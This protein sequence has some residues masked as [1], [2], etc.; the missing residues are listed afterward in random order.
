MNKQRAWKL[1]ALCLAV[2]SLTAFLLW[3]NWW[4]ISFRGTAVVGQTKS[5]LIDRHGPPEY[6]SR[7]TP[8]RRYRPRDTQERIELGLDDDSD[9]TLIWITGVLGQNNARIHFARGVAIGVERGS[10][11]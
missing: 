8:Y 11:R 3:A 5:L 7:V 10:H 2:A 1:A 9:Y 4:K 6:D